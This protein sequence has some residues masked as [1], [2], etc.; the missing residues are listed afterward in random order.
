MSVATS[1]VHSGDCKQIRL[2]H[3]RSILLTDSLQRL[4]VATMSNK[5]VF[6]LFGLN[7]GLVFLSM[8]EKRNQSIPFNDTVKS[9][10]SCIR[11][12]LMPIAV[13]TTEGR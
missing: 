4:L 8:A 9:W 13:A 3:L 5:D 12:G 6:L 11:Y 1:S 7:M 2:S 10:Y